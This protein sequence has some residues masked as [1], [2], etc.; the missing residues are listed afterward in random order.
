MTETVAE[1]AVKLDE[2]QK[3]LADIGSAIVKVA[4]IQKS[5]SEL[6]N[7]PK[8][9][10][11]KSVQDVSVRRDSGVPEGRP[12]QNDFEQ[13][14]TILNKAVA[15]GEIT[16]QKSAKIESE[17]QKAMKLGQKMSEETYSFICSKL[18]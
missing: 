17:V 6:P 10:M 4:E 13:V 18:K 12:D 2:L 7:E 3:S 5:F 8:T 16:L 9:V 1:Q 11:N 14:Q 15:D